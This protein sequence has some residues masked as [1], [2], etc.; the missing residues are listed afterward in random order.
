MCV[1]ERGGE[2]EKAR[3]IERRECDGNGVL[4][5]VSLNERF[6]ADE[7]LADGDDSF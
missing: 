7:I 4:F 5:V 3:G 1:R 6:W 2:R